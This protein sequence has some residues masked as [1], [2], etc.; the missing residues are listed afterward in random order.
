MSQTISP[1]D[2]VNPAL[3]PQF[4]TEAFLSDEDCNA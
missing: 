1:G 2:G 4:L 3:G